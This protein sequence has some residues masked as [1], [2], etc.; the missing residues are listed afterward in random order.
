LDVFGALNQ[1]AKGGER[2]HVGAPSGREDSQ[3]SF[4]LLASSKT[5]RGEKLEKKKEI[6]VG[7]GECCLAE[8]QFC[9]MTKEVGGGRGRGAFTMEGKLNHRPG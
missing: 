3:C 4:I 7:K 2:E 6:C 9:S 8:K 1:V 5:V